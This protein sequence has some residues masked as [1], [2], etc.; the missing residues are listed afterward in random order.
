MLFKRALQ[1]A[2]PLCL[3]ALVC[4]PTAQAEVIRVRST[5][6]H[7]VQARIASVPVTGSLPTVT[8]NWTRTDSTAAR[9]G[10]GIPAQFKSFCVD[11]EQAV[12]ANTNYTFD[13]VSPMQAGYTPEQELAL[14]SLW[15]SR[16]GDV[17]DPTTSAAFQLAVWEIRYDTD[18]NLGTGSFRASRPGG[19][20]ALA[21]QWLDGLGSTTLR[22]LPNLVVLQS[23]CA[24]DQITVVI[25]E[26][27]AAA[28]A[29]A[30]LA[31]LRRRRR[32]S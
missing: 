19:S 31:L 4:Q 27:G 10:S 26:P 8:F 7:Y 21:Q 9:A 6:S 28:C 29:L 14:R 30:G 24:Q 11:L 32:R 18:C 12:R 23:P 3:A 16:I 20:L 2:A 13:V 1:S 17:V 15:A 25:P 22:D 5:T